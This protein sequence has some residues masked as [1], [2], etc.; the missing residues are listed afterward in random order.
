MPTSTQAR[1]RSTP[2]TPEM[3]SR[4]VGDLVA[5][6]ADAAG[7]QVREVL[8]QPG[9]VDPGRRG[10]LAGG[11]GAPATVGQSRQHPEVHG[12]ACDGGLR[13]GPGPRLDHGLSTA[14]APGTGGRR[15]G[16]R[17]SGRGRCSPASATV[18]A[19]ER[20]NKVAD[21]PAAR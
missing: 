17:R 15:G 8:A 20:R 5:D 12:Q 10:Q 18:T 7:A 1:D 9:R 6:A 21:A 11:D 13:D 19:C 3:R 2:S 14:V 16:V 4:R